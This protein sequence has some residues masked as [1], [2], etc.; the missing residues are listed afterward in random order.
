VVE[1]FKDVRNGG[2]VVMGAANI[3]FTVVV[4]AWLKELA[5]DITSDAES[6]IGMLIT[7]CA[8]RHHSLLF[9]VVWLFFSLSFYGLPFSQSVLF[10]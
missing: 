3:G 8:T 2:L 6:A 1:A 5:G 4:T 9:P 10:E 7:R